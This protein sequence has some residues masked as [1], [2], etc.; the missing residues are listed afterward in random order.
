MCICWC[1]TEN[2]LQN[3]RCN[4][5]DSNT[6]SEVAIIVAFFVLWTSVCSCDQKLTSEI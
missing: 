4:D 3:A 2:K 5:K 6:L 1:V